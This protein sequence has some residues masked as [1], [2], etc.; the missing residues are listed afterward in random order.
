MTVACIH[1]PDFAPWLGFFD[2]LLDCDVFVVLDSVQFARRGWTHRDR[3]KTAQGAQWLTVP[4]V[5]KGRFDQAIREVEIDDARDWRTRHLAT[6]ATAYARAPF[7]DP[8][9]TRLAAIYRSGHERLVDLNM[10][11]LGWLME[12]LEITVEIRLASEMGATG[13]KSDLLVE[14][15]RR[16]GADVYLSGLGASDYLDEAAFAAAGIRVRW[17]D[18]RHP[19]YPQQHG[20]FIPMLSALDCLFNC[21]PAAATTLRSANVTCREGGKGSSVG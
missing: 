18:F 16:I 15:C 10:A 3:I 8:V 11:V 6:L 17:Q 7:R 1:Q 5:K 12:A 2:R 9:L 20:P 14:L 13:A 21:G 19:V 4:V